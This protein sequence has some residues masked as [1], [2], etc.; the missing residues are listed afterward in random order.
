MIPEVFKLAPN[1]MWQQKDKAIINAS[2]FIT[3]SKTTYNDLINNI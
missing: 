1:H 2:S 3:I